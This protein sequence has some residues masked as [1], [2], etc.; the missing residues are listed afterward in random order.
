MTNITKNG[1]SGAGA[2]YARLT[3]WLNGAGTIWVFA[4]MFLICADIAGRALFNSPIRGVPEMVSLSIVGCVF[5]QLAH[6]LHVGRIT[7]AEV[8]IE[9]LETK[10]RFAGALFNS[11]FHAT[12]ALI[13]A[14]LSYGTWPVF[15]RA[16]ETDE[17]AG[18]EGDFT[19]AVWP[20]KLI[21]VV[22]SAAMSIEFLGAL[23]G[24]IGKLAG[25]PRAKDWIFI[26]LLAILLALASS[27]AWADLDNSTIGL[28]S[29]LG[30]LLLIY[31]GMPIGIALMIL[32]FLGIWLMKGNATLAMNTLVL[33]ASGT[34]SDYVFATVPLFVLMGLF[35]SV[36]EIGRESFEVAQWA[37]GRLKGGLGVATVA[38][39][40]VFA[41]ITG[42][43]IAS[44]AI[45]TKIAVPPM[46]KAGYSAKFAVGLVA[47]SSV[48][49]MLIPPSLLLIIYGVIAEVS[50]GALF[51][52]AVIPGLLLA[53]SFAV[54]I[55][56]M[57]IYWPDF[58]G[59]PSTD[60][61]AESE[62]LRS[63]GRKIFPVVLLVGTVL[64]GIY[65]GLFTPTEA[66]AAGALAAM[67]IALAKGRLN[68]T[69]L[70]RVLIETGHVSVSILFLIIAASIYSR[71]LT[72]S[73][74]PMET[75]A[76]IGEAGLGLYGFLAFYLLI[77][78]VM[79]MILD[80]TSILLIV[81][82]LCLP[83]IAGF[84]GDL[85]WF[86]IITVIAVEIGL[87]TPPLGLSVYVIKASLDRDD[88]TLNSIFAGAFPFV[89]IMLAVTILLI[90]FPGISL[91]LL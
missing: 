69:K 16:F 59:R 21:I 70:W 62:T 51:V 6:T 5:L 42:I 52:A 85:I 1:V 76:M 60:F 63:A 9:W 88:L 54:A 17:F 7:R 53:T 31:A 44:A 30:M 43:S 66:G 15:V 58:V 41:S 24:Q 25:G 89:L 12:G 28:L 61:E 11:I 67:C 39:N 74:V 3:S 34:I 38:A 47:G 78:L 45:F 87:L 84:G 19:V 82:P 55:V 80:S 56:V 72:L 29:I 18:V 73:G 26:A 57:A 68:W 49:G 33:A 83:V 91:A 32:S 22:G 81:L 50:V 4:L 37:L 65:G 14:I 36:S 40:A 8:L 75:A 77:L 23:A 48:L 27:L 90:I 46:T 64:G 71:M 2:A 13:F 35:V 10:H 79:G 20:I 86:G